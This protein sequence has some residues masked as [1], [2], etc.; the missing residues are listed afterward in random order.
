MSSNFKSLP[1]FG[2]RQAYNLFIV[3]LTLIALSAGV[4]FTFFW[5]VDAPFNAKARDTYPARPTQDP[6]VF[7]LEVMHTW[8]LLVI[9]ILSM[10]FCWSE[11]GFF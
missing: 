11:T 3:R 10:H 7:T 1:F 6:S 4:P 2:R 8:K 5:L 9:E